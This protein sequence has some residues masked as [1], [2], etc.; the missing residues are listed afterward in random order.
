MNVFVYLVCLAVTHATRISFCQQRNIKGHKWTCFLCLG[1]NKYMYSCPQNQ[2][3]RK[4]CQAPRKKE[5]AHAHTSRAEEYTIV[6]SY[7]TISAEHIRLPT[8]LISLSWSNLN[9]TKA[10]FQSF[11]K[12]YLIK[13]NRKDASFA[14]LDNSMFSAQFRKETFFTYST[15]QNVN[16]VLSH[17]CTIN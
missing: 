8:H 16:H 11:T 2:F 14:S 13:V 6:L 3:L 5:C 1:R 12:C 4:Q 7:S 10:D 17:L 15:I 9:L